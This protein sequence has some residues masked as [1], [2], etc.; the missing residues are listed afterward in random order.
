MIKRLKF[1][2]FFYTIMGKD[3]QKGDAVFVTFNTS[4]KY[5]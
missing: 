5:K 3:D 2:E 4:K 1:S